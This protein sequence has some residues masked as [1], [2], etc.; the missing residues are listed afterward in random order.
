[1]M[2]GPENRF[3]L[4]MCQTRPRGSTGGTAA[5]LGAYLCTYVLR[6]CALILLPA[7]YVV[8]S[9]APL[10]TIGHTGGLDVLSVNCACIRTCRRLA[11]PRVA[12]GPGRSVASC[13]R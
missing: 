9:E 10:A 8:G 1:M 6:A 7:R 11:G 12:Q 13:G 4:V 2:A 3:F 5:G